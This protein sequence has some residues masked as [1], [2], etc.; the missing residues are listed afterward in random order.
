MKNRL[1]TLLALLVLA[2]CSKEKD[3]E[4]PAELVDI[5]PTLDVD[6]LWSV[7]LAGD[8]PNL[9]L[10]LGVASENG[11]VYA[12]GHGGEVLA[13]EIASGRQV[14]RAKTKS[15][16]GGATGVG[17]GLVVVGSTDGAVLAFDEKTGK[18]LWSA[19]V[20]GEI[21]AAP[22]VAEKA[23]VVRSVDG[24]LT[25]LAP[26]DGHELWRTEEQIPRLT[27]RGTAAPVVAGDLA[28]C[29]FDN[30][31]VVA[32]NTV[33][34]TVVWDTAVSPPRGR[35]ELERL[36]DIDS[37]VKVSGAD[38]FVVGFQGRAAMLALDSGQIWWS[39][40]LSSYRGLDV[41]DD[42]AY[43]TTDEG[44]VV[45]LRRRTGVELWRSKDLR[46][47]GLSAP[48]VVGNSVVV[49]DYKGIV[50]WFDKATGK[51]AARSSAGK[52]VSEAPLVVGDVVLVIDDAGRLSAFRPHGART[53]AAT[54]ADGSAAP[55]AAEPAAKP[56]SKP[57]APAKPA[58]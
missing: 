38:V 41:D 44:E 20:S 7:G 31:R 18:Q 16:L 48:A 29:G 25:G 56:A 30:G 23:V 42:A 46:R 5:K 28:L 55:G 34:G 14:W 37:P 3:I 9:R 43:V 19:R 17:Q 40:E 36:V 52:R 12:A 4:P 13:I 32:V 27:L 53:A 58:G 2:A 15:P 54:G 8:K 21:L 50:H 57:A 45:S 33:D 10:G 26:A 1:P 35:T 39:R 6:K 22:A 47:R 49:A 11:I 24:R 51:L